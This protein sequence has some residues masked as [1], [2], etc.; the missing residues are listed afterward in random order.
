MLHL[1]QRLPAAFLLATVVVTLVASVRADEPAPR[2]TPSTAAEAAAA[3][4]HLVEELQAIRRERSA[5]EPRRRD[6]LAKVQRQIEMLRSQLAP[7]ESAAAE[8]R[9]RIEQLEAKL[10][11][12]RKTA[13]ANCAWINQVSAAAVP[14]AAAA[15]GRIRRDSAE[16]PA[17]VAASFAAIRERLARSDASEQAAAVGELCRSFG[18]QWLPARTVSLTNERVALDSGRRAHHA[19]VYRSGL[20]SHVFVSEA[21]DVVGVSSGNSADPW[22]VE[23]PEA[24]QQQVRQLIAVAREQKPPTILPIPVRV[25]LDT[26][27]K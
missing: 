7:A 13:A 3:I 9:E 22:T 10:A 8:T 19:W 2:A 4:R 24:M 12:D 27:E 5:V 14:V 11:A 1:N 6:E 23:I 20:A 17:N 18:D 15:A 26:G 21:G 16:A 25:A